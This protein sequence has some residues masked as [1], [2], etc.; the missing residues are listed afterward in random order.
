[1]T[2]QFNRNSLTAAQETAYTAFILDENNADLPLDM[3]ASFAEQFE[4]LIALG[5]KSTALK[6]QRTVMN[7]IDTAQEEAEKTVPAAITVN[8]DM[9]PKAPAAIAMCVV[10]PLAQIKTWASEWNKKAKRAKKTNPQATAFAKQQ[11]GFAF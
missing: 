8:V 6:M 3:T 2:N 10:Q 4:Y 9:T 7:A 1:M 11:M 5:E